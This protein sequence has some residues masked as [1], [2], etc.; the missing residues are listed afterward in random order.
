MA[1]HEIRKAGSVSN[2][3][4]VPEVQKILHLSER[5]AP[6]KK[7]DILCLDNLGH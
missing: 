6:Q 5:S 7:D 4:Q 3:I 2:V 1:A